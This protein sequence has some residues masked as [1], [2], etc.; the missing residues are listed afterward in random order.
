[1]YETLTPKELCKILKTDEKNGLKEAEASHRLQRA[2]E[3]ILRKTKDRTI[4]DMIQEQ[5]NDPMIFILFLA[6]SIS[7]KSLLPCW[8]MP[9]ATQSA[10]RSPVIDLTLFFSCLRLAIIYKVR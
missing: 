9:K 8:H 1:M 7:S 6:A 5:I 2:G 4:G 3:N 10:K